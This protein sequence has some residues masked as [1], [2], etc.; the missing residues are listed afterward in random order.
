MVQVKK[1]SQS[2][3]LSC[4]V[5][6]PPFCILSASSSR[7]RLLFIPVPDPAALIS[8]IMDPDEGKI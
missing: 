7:T 6:K 3:S 2:F 4:C 1:D 5:V 8:T